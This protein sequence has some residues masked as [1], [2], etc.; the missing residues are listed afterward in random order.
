MKNKKHTL[1]EKLSYRFDKLMSKGTVA[2]VG[3]LAVATFIMVIAMGICAAAINDASVGENIWASLMHAIDAGTLAGDTGDI[4]YI[5]LMAIV[6][7]FGIFITSVL[8]GILNN[9]LESKMESLK[10]GKSRVIESHHIVILGFTDNVYT[11]INELIEANSNHSHNVIVVMDETDKEEMEEAI[12]QHTTQTSKTEIICRSGNITDFTDLAMCSIETAQSVIIDTPD[13]FITIKA[14]L[15]VTHIL[16]NNNCDAYFAAVINDKNNYTA[17]VDASEGYGEII[18]FDDAI[19]KIMAHTFRYA[20]LSAV[21]E[22]LFDFSGHEFYI[23][24][25]PELTG[26]TISEANLHLPSSVAIGLVRDGQCFVNPKSDEIIGSDDSVILIAP[27]DNS[28]HPNDTA[29]TV[30]L[31]SINDVQPSSTSMIQKMLIIGYSQKLERVI[32]ELDKYAAAGSTVIVAVNEYDVS[33]VDNLLDDH[34]ENIELDIRGCDICSKAG[35][36]EV[37]DDDIKNILVMTSNIDDANADDARILVTLLNLR[38]IAKEHGFDFNITS[39]MRNVEN[40]ELASITDVQDFVISS[41]ITSLLLTQISQDRHFKS[42]FEELLT[43]EGSEIYMY[44]ATECVKAG[45]PVN[46]Y[47]VGEAVAQRH[48][49]MIGYKL[50]NEIVLNPVKEKHVTFGDKDSIIVIAED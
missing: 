12:K 44:P 46:M 47:T 24:H 43:D 3:I 32:N 15:A 7:F 31:D 26:M 22:D 23:E 2:L 30:D 20:G 16:K 1:R 6:T 41:N 19:S 39:E 25:L 27:D 36:E 48:A 10:K 38:I 11:V 37:L 8:I 4:T 13:D 35:I 5:A 49:V 42:I 40:Q 29:A 45:V 34:Y 28:S 50:G 33:H 17:A 14:I 18:F 21:F 9:G